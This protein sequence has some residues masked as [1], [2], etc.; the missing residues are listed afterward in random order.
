MNENIKLKCEHH[1]GEYC[2]EIPEGVS[3][4]DAFDAIALIQ[5]L[6]LLKFKGEKCQK[7]PEKKD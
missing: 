1:S 6:I 7:D 3:L 4:I 2:I 5:K